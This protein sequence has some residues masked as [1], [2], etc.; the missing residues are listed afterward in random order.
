MR[1]D[2]QAKREAAQLFRF[3]KRNGS[4]DEN[5]VRQAARLV[6]AA[7]YRESPAVLAHFL[8]LV[9]LEL[10]RNTAK[11]ESATPLPD[12]LRAATRA[13]LARVYGEGLTTA[14]V[15]KPSLIG[16]MRI[17]V[18]SDVYDSTV[19]GRLAAMEKTF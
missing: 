5:R 1:I 18:G 3:C 13:S 19:L 16:G 8:R 10:E 11:I 2:R 6:I 4:L 14:F 17:Q 12:D 9:R 15:E 7:G